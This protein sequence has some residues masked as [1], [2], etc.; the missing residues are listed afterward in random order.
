MCTTPIDVCQPS[1]W[2]GHDRWPL[3]LITANVD[4]YRAG[5]WNTAMH[6]LLMW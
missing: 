4:T 3:E 1:R 5:S 6:N 2:I